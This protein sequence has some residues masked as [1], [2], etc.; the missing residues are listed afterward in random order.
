MESAFAV[1]FLKVISASSRQLPKCIA[2]PGEF[3]LSTNKIVLGLKKKLY[4]ISSSY[5]LSILS[6]RNITVFL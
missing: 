4:Q 2:R 1:T 6:S 3:L 5:N